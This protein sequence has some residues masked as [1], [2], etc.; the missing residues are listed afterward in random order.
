MNALG[1]DLRAN[2]QVTGLRG[3]LS[4]DSDGEVW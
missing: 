4:H 2:G 1:H 3:S